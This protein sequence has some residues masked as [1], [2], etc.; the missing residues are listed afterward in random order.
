MKDQAWYLGHYDSFLQVAPQY[1]PLDGW[2]AKLSSCSSDAFGQFRLA[3]KWKDGFQE[4][5]HRYSF[6][7]SSKADAPSAVIFTD[8]YGAPMLKFLAES[9]SKTHIYW[10]DVSLSYIRNAQPDVVIIEVA[11][12]FLAN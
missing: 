2:K 6:T 1:L 3:Y 8:S 11:E 4:G 9:F 7:N 12:R 10:E 5:N